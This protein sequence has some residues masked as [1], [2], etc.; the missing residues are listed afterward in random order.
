MTQPALG[1]NAKKVDAYLQLAYANQYLD[2]VIEDQIAVL[3]QFIKCLDAPQITK[4]SNDGVFVEDVYIDHS[5]ASASIPVAALNGWLQANTDNWDVKAIELS[6]PIQLNNN[7]WLEAQVEP[8]TPSTGE[9]LFG[10]LDSGCPFAH[11]DITANGKTRVIGLWAQGLVYKQQSPA[12]FDYGKRFNH[13]KLNAMLSRGEYSAYQGVS[14]TYLRSQLSHGAPV[15]NLI[16]G[17]IPQSSRW[18]NGNLQPTWEAESSSAC[19]ADIVCVDFPEKALEDSTGR[20]LGRYVLDGI[21][22]ILKHRKNDGQKIIIN[23]SYGPTTGPHDGSSL[24][25]L[26]FV[27][28]LNRYQNLRLVVAA[29]NSRLSRLHADIS[30]SKNVPKTIQWLVPPDSASV[31]FAEIWF[32]AATKPSEY[33]VALFAPDGSACTLASVIVDSIR[34]MAL[35][36]ISP[37]AST[38]KAGNQSFAPPGVWTITLACNTDQGGNTHVYV[39][40]TDVNLGF[41]RQAR[42]SKLLDPDA[43]RLTDG[44]IAKTGTLNGIGTAMHD[45]FYIVGGLVHTTGHAAKYSGAGSGRGARQST[46]R[47]AFSEENGA[48]HG[49]LAGGTRSQSYLRLSGTSLAAPQ[50]ARSLA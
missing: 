49:I 16:A 39:A 18:T 7:D 22:F 20:W 36:R 1:A 41:P 17:N 30:L 33:T 37:T 23:L 4:L 48:L 2:F 11:K 15:L 43:V 13:G 46:N 50:F 31:N 24:L 40:N 45:R 32:P 6:A 44:C 14:P 9:V 3:V 8:I 47:Q 29:G 35:L 21:H 34:N 28:L 5:I 38:S 10:V 12:L 19:Q 26:A 27:E 25:E 42:P